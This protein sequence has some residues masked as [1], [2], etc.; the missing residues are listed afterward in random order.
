M[1]RSDSVRFAG[2]AMRTRASACPTGVAQ[3]GQKSS[4]TRAP[5]FQQVSLCEVIISPFRLP[6]DLNQLSQQYSPS[7]S[8]VSRYTVPTG[9]IPWSRWKFR[10]A[11]SVWVP[12]QPSTAIETVRLRP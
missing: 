2:S 10:T 8:H 6:H 4:R 12:N 3:D 5:H 7:A 11:Y 9:S 1:S